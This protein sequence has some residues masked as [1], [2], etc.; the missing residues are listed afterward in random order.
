[1]DDVAGGPAAF[2]RVINAA[3]GGSAQTT[4]AYT[5]WPEEDRV[6]SNA[7]S[8]MV[9]DF[10]V[11]VAEKIPGVETAVS[12]PLRGISGR[13]EELVRL[14]K[15]HEESFTILEQNELKLEECRKNPTKNP[16]QI[17]VGEGNVG[18]RHTEVEQQENRFIQEVTTVWTTRYQLIGD[19]LR[20]FYAIVKDIGEALSNATKPVA[21]A[22]GREAMERSYQPAGGGHRS[23]EGGESPLA[24]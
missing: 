5:T 2:P 12:H 6:I 24:S 14:R 19:P 7:L 18:T 8:T 20:A 1:M 9:Q 23:P 10:G 21:S 3:K 4:K 13:L 11:Y 22:V 15:E 17:A 16:E